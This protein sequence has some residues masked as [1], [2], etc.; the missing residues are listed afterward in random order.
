MLWFTKAPILWVYIQ[1]FGVQKWLRWTSYAT[2]AIYGAGLL[3]AL[4]ITFARC[5]DDLPIC[6]TATVLTGVISGFFA[7]AADVVIFILPIPPI[8]NLQLPRFKKIGLGIAFSSGI[9]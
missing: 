4:C 8:W 3:A 7:I 1:L 6:S 9:L 5:Q 2:M